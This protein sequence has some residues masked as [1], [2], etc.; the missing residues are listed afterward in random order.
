VDLAVLVVSVE[1]C[2][3]LRVPLKE[4]VSSATVAR[5]ALRGGTPV[6]ITVNL[7]L[8]KQS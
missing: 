8:N 1:Y 3:S 7:F 4:R 2:E 5:N 6:G